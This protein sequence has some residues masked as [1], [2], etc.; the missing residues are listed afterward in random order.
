MEVLPHVARWY[1]AGIAI[2]ATAAMSRALWTALETT[3]QELMLVSILA[4]GVALAWRFPVHLQ[5]NKYLSVDEVTAQGIETT[6][7]LVRARSLGCKLGQ[8]Y[9]VAHPLRPADLGALLHRGVGFDVARNAVGTHLGR[10]PRLQAET[11]RI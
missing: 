9:C 10:I 1:I 5:R 11:A 2:V 6:N 7:D 3:G 8:G 4:G